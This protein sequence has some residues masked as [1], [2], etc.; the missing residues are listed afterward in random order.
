[1]EGVMDG[2]PRQKTANER[3]AARNANSGVRQ[4]SI[5]RARR[6]CLDALPAIGGNECTWSENPTP[7][8]PLL[9]HVGNAIGLLV[10]PLFTVTA[11][12]SASDTSR[13]PDGLV[14]SHI[15]G[16]I[17]QSERWVS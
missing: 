4:R 1:M 15:L 8:C 17:D 2:A 11:S 3:Q 7:Q 6:A 16:S 13:P 10:T 14:E 9:V 5:A 12:N